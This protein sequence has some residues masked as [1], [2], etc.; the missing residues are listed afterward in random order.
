LVAEIERARDDGV[1]ERFL[2]SVGW[3][4]GPRSLPMLQRWRASYPALE[5]FIERI[6]SGR[7]P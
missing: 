2:R 1:R 7:H 6:G 5:Y 3:V 4:G